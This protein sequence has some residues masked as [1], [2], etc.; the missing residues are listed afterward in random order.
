MAT[1]DAEPT[2]WRV[3]AR[4]GSRVV[5]KPTPLSPARAWDLVQSL[6]NEPLS[7]AVGAV[8]DQHR[9][10]TQ[11]RAQALAAEL[12]ALHAELAALPA[13][14]DPPAAG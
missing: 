11:A 12:Q 8:L 13:A 5:I 4:I 7:T 3:E 1:N 6:D 2:A 10:A 9:Q 14:G